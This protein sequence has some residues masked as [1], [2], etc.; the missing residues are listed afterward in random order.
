MSIWLLV[1]WFFT[2]LFHLVAIYIS[3][4]SKDTTTIIDIVL[5]I[6]LW[7]TTFILLQAMILGL[8]LRGLEERCERFV[9]KAMWIGIV[10]AYMY[11]LLRLLWDSP[12]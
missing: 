4:L 12:R 3:G 5:S 9:L 2:A 8:M 11:G 1:L 7:T 10:P 6:L